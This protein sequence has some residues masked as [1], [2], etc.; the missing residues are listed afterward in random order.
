MCVSRSRIVIGAARRHLRHVAALVGDRDRRARERRN[1][2]AGARRQRERSLL[3][4][5]HDRGAGQRLGL[6][7]DPEDRVGR[8]APARFLVGPAE[9]L[10]VDDLAV[11]HHQRDDAG[12]LVGVDISLQRAIDDRRPRGIE[13]ELGAG[14]LGGEAG[15][16]QNNDARRLSFAYG[17]DCAIERA[18]DGR[19]KGVLHA[20]AA[21][22]RP[23]SS[24]SPSRPRAA[25]RGR[26]GFAGRSRDCWR[27]SRCRRSA[28]R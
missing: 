7:R 22:D 3:D 24:R 9:R 18:Y 6:R 13:R 4:Q 14:R 15:A 20:P 11:L 28:W 23:R 5:L 26:A 8:H 1:Q 16:E 27:S 21:V 12:D 10:L 25:R 17:A 2:G 19:L